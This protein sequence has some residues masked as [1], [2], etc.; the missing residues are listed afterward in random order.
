MKQGNKHVNI[1][2]LFVFLIPLQGAAQNLLVNGSFEEENYCTEYNINCA[3]E[4]WIYTVPSFNY[5]FKGANHLPDGTHYIAV[6][7]GNSRKVFYRSFVRSRLLCGLRKDST[8]RLRV[9]VKS[10]HNVLDSMGIYFS[11]GDFLLEKRPFRNIV[12]SIYLS[13]ARS[14]KVSDTNWQQVVID[15]RAVGNENFISIGNFA[16]KDIGGTTGIER[17]DNFFVLFD[18]LS[19]TP[20]HHNEKLC[21]DWLQTRDEIYAQD[22]R[23]EFLDRWIKYY[24]NK[25]EE[26][27][28]LTQT[29]VQT[30]DTIVLPDI[31]FERGSSL[32]SKASGLYLDSVW[33][34]LHG[35][36]VDSIVVE[37]HTDST[38]SSESNRVLGYQRATV[39]VRYLQSK[40]PHTEFFSR[41]W[42][43]QRPVSNNNSNE[44]RQ[45]NRRVEIYLYIRG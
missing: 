39:V 19:L 18:D 38:G 13:D 7:A 45:K 21:P 34:R 1:L 14:I 42:A 3:P 30:V 24:R 27:I 23:H 31:L 11:K 12:P 22:E 15:Y 26:Y 5:Y 43:A 29:T 20:V 37:G 8:Y 9:F 36:V 44:G 40:V 2:Y 33:Q 41:S 4:G 35:K 25:P 16:V 6:V 10:P 28:N 17:E 32:L